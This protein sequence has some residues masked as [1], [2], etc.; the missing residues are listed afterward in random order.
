MDV[1]GFVIECGV[2]SA[3]ET[4]SEGVVSWH[5]MLLLAAANTSAISLLFLFFRS[6]LGLTFVCSAL[7]RRLSNIGL[8][9]FLA[10]WAS[11]LLWLFR[12][13]ASRI[14]NFCKL[15]HQSIERSLSETLVVLG[16]LITTHD[17]VQLS[18]AVIGWS[19]D[20]VLRVAYTLN[21]VFGC[22]LQLVMWELVLHKHLVE[23]RLFGRQMLTREDGFLALFDFGRMRGVV[24][25]IV[26]AHL[27]AEL[28][29]P[30][31]CQESLF[32][33]ASD[34]LDIV[35]DLVGQS[36]QDSVGVGIEGL[37]L[38]TVKAHILK[39]SAGLRHESHRAL[40]H[41]CHSIVDGE[42]DDA[43]G[44]DE[45]IV[46]T[47][48]PIRQLILDFINGFLPE[49]PRFREELGDAHFSECIKQWLSYLAVVSR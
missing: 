39:S 40:R 31:S 18:H 2:V 13:D 35:T 24:G 15:C 25:N 26:H 1:Q 4:A 12:R 7:F 42:F 16:E 5:L 20:I 19:S 47:M 33:T 41:T 10:L 27:N 21:S 48:V 11:L 30:R 17:S 36:C 22:S 32:G 23:S 6:S 3:T 34:F 9:G 8:D 49:L 45:E 46:G 14:I 28:R 44:T 29:M 43:H 37:S 38:S